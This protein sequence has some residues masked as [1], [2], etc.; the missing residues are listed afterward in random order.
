MPEDLL[1]ERKRTLEEEF[2]R[3]A[4]AAVLEQLRATRKREEAR[5]ALQ[6]ASGISD[7][8]IIDRLIDAGIDATAISAL[9]V[10]PMVAAGWADGK[11]E[12]EERRAILEGAAAMGL[13]EGSQ[14]R[15][16]LEGW[17]TQPP[18]PSMLAAWGDYVQGLSQTLPP[19]L[20]VA[21]G[22]ETLQRA[23][24]T[25]EARGGFMGLGSKV[26]PE[27]QAVLERIK[28]AFGL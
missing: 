3:N 27:E 12:P 7:S 6:D 4:N 9:E 21:L 18:P 24:A 14:G 20:R 5:L 25:A 10:V 28:R 15:A 19:D 1:G 26:S 17:L 22:N 11:L 8:A 23:R 16:M 2:F 13:G